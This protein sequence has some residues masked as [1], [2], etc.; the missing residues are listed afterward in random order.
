MAGTKLISTAE[1][2]LAQE[3]TNAPINPE[4]MMEYHQEVN[5]SAQHLSNL[6]EK[7]G[8]KV[9][10]PAGFEKLLD[11]EKLRN[12]N[13]PENIS[14]DLDALAKDDPR[15]FVE[16]IKTNPELFNQSVANHFADIILAGEANTV[17][18]IYS[19]VHKLIDNQPDFA[20]KYENFILEAAIAGA[21]HEG[22]AAIFLEDKLE[23]LKNLKSFDV[24]KEL[25]EGDRRPLTTSAR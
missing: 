1:V 18:E 9:D 7:H 15:G 16:Q 11:N 2:A 14:R 8:M 17:A 20:Q 23:K 19:I 3:K 5:L 25:Y 24:L 10:M 4:A 13:A 22:Y 21:C 6:E 12:A